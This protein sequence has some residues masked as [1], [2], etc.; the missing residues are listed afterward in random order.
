[1]FSQSIADSWLA[2]I[3]KAE[4][5]PGWVRV[6]ADEAAKHPISLLTLNDRCGIARIRPPL[7]AQLGVTNAELI[8]ADILHAAIAAANIALNG[9]DYVHYLPIETQQQLLAADCSEQTRQLTASD[10][11][12]F[13]AMID[14]APEDDI[15]EAYVELDHWLVYGTFVD[16]KLVC[17]ASMYPW[18]GTLLADL[19]VITPPKFRGRGYARE[20][21][22]AMSAH[23]LR[24]GYEP[25]YRCQLD[26]AASVALAASAGFAR[27]GEWDVAVD[28]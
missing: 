26:N 17:A 13:Q 16:G 4:L 7:A 6:V 19:G 27:F 28:S 23:A 10:A 3:T 9:A 20:T 21:V 18:D 15:D 14:S 8:D 22:R 5:E 12:A 2:G 1:M 11:E 24:D 25:Q